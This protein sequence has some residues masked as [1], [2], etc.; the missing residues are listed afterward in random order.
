MFPTA[1]CLRRP[2]AGGM[3]QISVGSETPNDRNE[4]PAPS[5]GYPSKTFGAESSAPPANAPAITPEKSPE[6]FSAEASEQ[7]DAESEAADLPS[8]L[9]FSDDRIES[10]MP[11]GP[12]VAPSAWETEAAQGEPDPRDPAP[13]QT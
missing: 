10:V 4:N 9:D 11:D 7:E 12:N 3:S 6:A 5:D 2:Y 8:P 13:R 1:V